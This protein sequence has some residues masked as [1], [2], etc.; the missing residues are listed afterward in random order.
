MRSLICIFILCFP[1]ISNAQQQN[2]E[3]ITSDDTTL[4][5]NGK[6]NLLTNGGFNKLVT[7]N[8]DYLIAGGQSLSNGFK[9]E[10]LNPSGTY[11]GN[12]FINKKVAFNCDITGGTNNNF[13]QILAGNKLNGYLKYSAG[14]NLLLNKNFAN[15]NKSESDEI[16]YEQSYFINIDKNIYDKVIEAEVVNELHKISEKNQPVYNNFK[17]SITK[18]FEYEC[19]SP[20][21]K[22]LYNY[23]CKRLDD[24]NEPKDTFLIN[25]FKKYIDKKDI[26]N[27]SIDTAGI[28]NFSNIIDTLLTSIKLNEVDK[29]T[30]NTILTSSYKLES[31][32]V[33]ITANDIYKKLLIN[34]KKY[35]LKLD[36][37]YKE[38]KSY[39]ERNE[40]HN[41]LKVSLNNDAY[42]DSIYSKEIKIMDPYWTKTRLSWINLSISG[43][44]NSFTMF[45]PS[46]LNINNAIYDTTSFLPSITFSYN[47]FVKY[48]HN[49]GGFKLFTLGG[50]L[51]NVSSTDDL[52]TITY[53][54]NET[55][56]NSSTDSI[57]NRTKSGTAY[58]GYLSKGFGATLYIE[59]YYKPWGGQFVPGIYFK[60]QYSYGQVWINS[61]KIALYL[62]LIFN[63]NNAD[64]TTDK[65]TLTIIPY[66]SVS[67]VRNDYQDVAHTIKNTIQNLISVGI[68]VGIPIFIN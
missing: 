60:G 63:V 45:N 53:Q 59:S 4:L 5:K 14:V 2:R 55:T 16:K 50:S 13:T 24:K 30:L 9:F 15:Y 19:T 62:G 37:D 48:N 58:K 27:P 67:D 28:N 1:F 61:S 11:S 68:K 29:K 57:L 66:A 39:L 7:S 17:T 10:A 51:T 65:N 36:N 44:N 54:L 23:V 21:D 52:K 22:Y 46:A 33:E 26:T 41:N 6:Y 64:K 25:I 56:T 43:N 3:Y 20:E 8:Y 49:V 31:K 38:T 35:N 40:R 34:L 42:K 47:W 12:V 18:F 32:D